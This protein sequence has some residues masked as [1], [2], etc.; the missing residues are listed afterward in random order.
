MTATPELILVCCIGNT[1]RSPAF[2]AIY[3][4]EAA[5]RGLGS[6]AISAALRRPASLAAAGRVDSLRRYMVRA[7]ELHPSTQGFVGAAREA[8]ADR[9]KS[10]MDLVGLRPTRVLLLADLAEVTAEADADAVQALD[11][12][13]VAREYASVPDIGWIAFEASGYHALTDPHGAY[14]LDKY[15]EQ[16]GM[17][18]GRVLEALGTQPRSGLS[19]ARAGRS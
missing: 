19:P 12:Y 16:T 2:A 6:H 7:L 5:V 4:A 10:V 3:N 11:G 8:E 15:V 17:L 1:C 13:G 14:V 18:H 9:P